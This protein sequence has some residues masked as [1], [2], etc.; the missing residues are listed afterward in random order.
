[1]PLRI[2][3]RRVIRMPVKPPTL[4]FGPE[5]FM[6][7]LERRGASPGSLAWKEQILATIPLFETISKRHRRSIARIATLVRFHVG[8]PLV[9]EGSA[10]TLFGVVVDGTLRVVRNG[11]TV[12]RLRAGEF[13]GEVAVLHPGPRTASIVAHTDGQCMTIEGEKIRRLLWKEPGIGAEIARVL[14]G[15]LREASRSP[16]D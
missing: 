7:A 10:G 14:A 15:R 6:A 11:R 5:A 12:G 1:M 2:A 16:T 3:V 4:P 9:T 8:D 13:F